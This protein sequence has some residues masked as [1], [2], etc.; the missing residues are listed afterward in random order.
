MARDPSRTY[1][2]DVWGVAREA[3]AAATGR[4]NRQPGPD[5]TFCPWGRR[6][7]VLRDT[8]IPGPISGEFRH[9]VVGVPISA[10]DVSGAG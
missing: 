5:L 6:P 9:G 8:N 3:I 10:H 7:I 4:S 1:Y 2:R